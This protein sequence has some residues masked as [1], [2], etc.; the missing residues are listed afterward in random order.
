M[1]NF[2]K[3]SIFIC[4]VLIV[5]SLA[6]CGKKDVKTTEVEEEEHESFADFVDNLETA[7]DENQEEEPHKSII[8][9]YGSYNSFF[10]SIETL[11]TSID[12]DDGYDKPKRGFFFRKK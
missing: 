6:G 4:F 8:D 5:V 2:K 12:I 11:D 7:I 10:D 9:D 1:K 3:L